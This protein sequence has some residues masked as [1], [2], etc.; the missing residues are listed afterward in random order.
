MGLIKQEETSGS[1]VNLKLVAE[2]WPTKE[3]PKFVVKAKGADWTWGL[4]DESYSK[5]SGTLS[6]ISTTHNGKTGKQEVKGFK[7]CLVDWE[8]KI[9][10]DTT[11][12]NASKDL[13]NH[14]LANIGK[15][16][17]ISLYLNW[18]D[19]PSASVKYKDWTH[20]STSQPFDKLD[21]EKLWLDIKAQEAV[22]EVSSDIDMDAIPF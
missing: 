9:Y 1:S 17:L 6:F 21:R 14:L 16:V 22:K 12:T 18:K 3:F 2:Q 15:E 11:L 8:E 19:Y 10:V 7:F 5:I 4:S 20:T 13:W